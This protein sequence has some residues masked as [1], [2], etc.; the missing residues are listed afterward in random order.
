[1]KFTAEEEVDGEIPFLDCLITKTEGNKLKTKVYKKPTHTGQYTNFYSNQPMHVKLSTI[2][3]LTR[4]AKTICMEKS[5]LDNELKYIEKTMQLNEYP[6]SIVKKAITETLNPKP[7]EKKDKEDENMIKM[8]LPYEKGIS[9]NIARIS[10]KFNVKLVN[11]KGKSLQKLVKPK[12]TT[13]LNN[14]KESG[15]VYKVSCENCDKKYIGETGRRLETRIK[16]HKKG[17]EGE[18]ENVSGLSQHIKQTKH[19]IKFDDVEI[20]H[21]ES[22]YTKRKFKEALAIKKGNEQLMNK[23]EEIKL[24]SDV[25][26]NII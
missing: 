24:L 20:L 15:V 25:W 5:D 13:N 11:T 12:S 18:K 16:E 14:E 21:R 3:T 10:R 23:K 17:A 7:K 1:M 8:Y 19:K 4:R 22:D 2:K 9:E 6:R 26:E